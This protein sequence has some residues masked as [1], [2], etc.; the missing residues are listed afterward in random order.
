MELHLV[1]EVSSETTLKVLSVI[2]KA[3]KA[4][5]KR[6]VNE[7]G[8][9]QSTID[10]KLKKLMRLKLIEPVPDISE[11]G[12]PI[13]PY[14]LTKYGEIVYKKLEEL[15]LLLRRILETPSLDEEQQLLKQAISNKLKYD[16]EVKIGN[17][18]DV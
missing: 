18:K 14:K 4:H 5:W 16:K 7:T 2:K 10:S 3:G 12:R 17:E 15:D 9:S 6:I 13:K 11:T 8:L 1:K